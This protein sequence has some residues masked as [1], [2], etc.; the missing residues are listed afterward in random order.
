MEE[1]RKIIK[2]KRSEKQQHQVDIDNVSCEDSQ[3]E[4]LEQEDVIQR[5]SDDDG[6]WESDSSSENG[7]KKD[8]KVWNEKENPLKEDEELV[9]DSSA[10]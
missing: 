6:E 4:I 3:E 2:V 1:P 10:Y 5:D 7:K 8:K 9:F